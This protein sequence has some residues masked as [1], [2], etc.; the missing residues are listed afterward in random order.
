MFTN[1][2]T[3]YGIRDILRHKL[4]VAPG[5]DGEHAAPLHYY[6]GQDFL[7]KTDKYVLDKVL[8]HK[9]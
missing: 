3:R 6:T 2:V 7:V 9:P 4:Q 8:D 5:L 1:R